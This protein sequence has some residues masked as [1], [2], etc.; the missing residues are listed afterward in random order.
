VVG[1]DCDVRHVGGMR[2]RVGHVG[3]L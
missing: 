2:Q 1:G 3:K